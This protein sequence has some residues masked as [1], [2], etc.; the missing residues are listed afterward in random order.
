M[1]LPSPHLQW[2]ENMQLTPS[3]KAHT[4]KNKPIWGQIPDPDDSL[5]GLM[6]TEKKKKQSL[7]IFFQKKRILTKL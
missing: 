2:K 6:M 7:K 5:P 4:H 3:I 1:A